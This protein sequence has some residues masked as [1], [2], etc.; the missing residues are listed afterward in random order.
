[1]PLS[2]IQQ[3]VADDSHRFR[4]VI[5]GRRVGKSTLAIRELCR[6]AAHPDVN[7]W[8]IGPSY[9]SI[10]MTLWKPLKR[11]L[12][13]QRWVDKI[14]ESSLEITLKNGSTISLKGSDNPDSLRGAKLWFA[15]IDEIADCD[16]DLFPEIIR[17]ALADSQGR[18]LMIGT[19]KGKSN[20]SF[21]LYNQQLD[22]P[23]QWRS[24]TFTTLQGGFVSMEE[25][26]AA[27]KDM[28]EKLFRQ[29][30]EA[31]FETVEAQIAW[32]FTRDNIAL[33]PE[34]LS[35]ELLHIGCDFNVSPLCA[36]IMVRQG[37]RM[38]AIDEIQMYSSNTHELAEE[39]KNRYPKSR[40]WVY[41]DPAGSARTTKSN[42][43]DH[44]I[45]RNAGF[46]VKAP[47]G[48]D[49]IRDRF[50]SLNNR[51]CT[52]DGIRHLF[53]SPKCK[54]TIESLEK[55]S[56]RPGTQIP[57]KGG[58]PDYSH[59]FDALSYCIA[60]IWPIKRPAVEIPITSWGHKL[61]VPRQNLARM[62]YG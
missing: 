40:I 37:D 48:H 14:N 32:A 61:A 53:I 29:E 39:I 7:V 5:A 20:H 35:H 6:H 33:P 57:D 13:D 21:D 42:Q 56:Y 9:R 4:V 50:N 1:M 3:E 19:P 28:S 11:K 60:Y 2:P 15:A 26:T 18:A 12:L 17:P 47:A 22:N 31:S 23:E 36:S 16:P 30:F 62:N 51:L 34:D 25:I 27:R 49:P 38:W 8:A 52:A 55:Y 45:L 41:P 24:W 10:K 59:M 43:S 44:T 58:D 46:I 54:Y